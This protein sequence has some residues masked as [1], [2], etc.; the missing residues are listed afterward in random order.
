MNA[1][2]VEKMLATVARQLQEQQTKGFEELHRYLQSPEFGR[3]FGANRLPTAQ[4]HVHFGVEGLP[5]A[6]EAEGQRLA[7]AGL[8]SVPEPHSPIDLDDDQVNE[9]DPQ[10]TQILKSRRHAATS[11]DGQLLGKLLSQPP[12]LLDLKNAQSDIKLFQDVPESPPPTRQI[13]DKRLFDAQV[14]IEAALHLI[15]QSLDINDKQ[16]TIEAAAWLRSSWEDLLQTRRKAFAGK[17]SWKLDARK[18]DNKPKLVSPEEEKK[19]RTGK[20]KGTGKGTGKG[21]GQW[22][23]Q[24][25]SSSSWG[26]SG[27]PQ[28]K[29]WNYRRPRSSSAPKKQEQK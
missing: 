22:G 4:S 6:P 21:K 10:W 24:R 18:D 19:L 5:T 2:E 13:Q 14:K 26:S 3:A 1:E 12:P 16:P 23:N 28:Q 27:R 20:G 17:Q 7:P 25:S 15:M 8:P 9:V 11:P 29:S